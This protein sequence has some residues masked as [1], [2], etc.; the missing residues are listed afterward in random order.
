MRSRN[1]IGR[2]RIRTSARI[3]VAT[4]ATV[5]F[6]YV[7]ARHLLDTAAGQGWCWWW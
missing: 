3:P 1:E 5:A 6:L 7:F 2:A 4:A